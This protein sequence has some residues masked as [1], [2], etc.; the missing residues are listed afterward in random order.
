MKAKEYHKKQSQKVEEKQN[1]EK[2]NLFILE[3]N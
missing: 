2:I 3:R 1:N